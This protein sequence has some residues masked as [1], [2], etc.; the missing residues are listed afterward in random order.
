MMDGAAHRGQPLSPTPTRQAEAQLWTRRGVGHGVSY[1][2]M[3]EYIEIRFKKNG[4]PLRV[5]RELPGGIEFEERDPVER[6]VLYQITGRSEATRMRMRHIRRINGWAPGQFWLEPSVDDGAL[7]IRGATKY[8]LP[9]GDYELRLQIEEA[10]VSQKNRFVAVPHDGGGTMFA[11]VKMDERTIT[12]TLEGCD[13]CVKQV[14]ERSAV[15]GRPARGWLHSSGPRATRRACLLNLLASLRVQPTMAQPFIHLVHHVHRVGHDRVYAKVDRELLQ[16]VQ[17][18]ALDPSKP[19]YEEG[20]PRAEIHG[21]LLATLPEPPEVK[22]W[23]QTLVSFR[24]EGK[25]SLH[26]VIAVPPPQLPY[27]YAEF[28]L[29]LSNPLQDLVGFVGHMGEL[30]DGKSTNHLDLRKHLAKTKARDYLCYSIRTS[31]DA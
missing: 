25:P 10:S 13:Q 15:D 7:V 18:L 21:Q 30:L 26:I 17:R 24:S 2:R 29:D 16:R 1:R 6:T 3:N 5:K 4:R 27:A 22:V 12:V 28:D 31:N 11:D 19:F 8:S 9:E 23:F 14:I 20:P